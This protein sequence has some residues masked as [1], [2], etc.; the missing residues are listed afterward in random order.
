MRP[1]IVLR[2]HGVGPA[3]RSGFNGW[4]PVL[5]VLADGERRIQQVVDWTGGQGEKPAAGWFVGA[6]GFVEHYAAAV[7]IRGPEGP[8]APPV[9]DLSVTA[10]KI[11]SGAVT[12]DK[13]A[14]DAVTGDK[15]A[16]AAVTSGKLAA[17]AVG[18]EALADAAV[19]GGKLAE[20]AVGSGHLGDGVVTAAKIAAGSIGPAQLAQVTAPCVLGNSGSGAGLVGEVTPG[21]L[22]ALLGRTWRLADR[23]SPAGPVS[24]LTFAIPPDCTRWRLSTLFM[25]T[26]QVNMRYSVDGGDTFI[27]DAVY[28]RYGFYQY[29]TVFAGIASS[30]VNIVNIGGGGAG[31]GTYSVYE[32]AFAATPGEVCGEVRYAHYDGSN[33]QTVII[34]SVA[35]LGARPTHFRLFSDENL[36]PGTD[37][38]LEVL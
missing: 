28:Q 15:L 14:S 26:Q 10:D 34:R 25:A 11:A 19:T 16:A 3:G 24:T 30:L 17:G 23:Q 1:S 35:M 4:T 20:A 5:A 29:N 38:L 31:H 32:A 7:D 2:Q 9:L 27:S 12:A 8:S 13:L 37:C 33:W 21:V 6:Q 36:Q 18:A 22:G